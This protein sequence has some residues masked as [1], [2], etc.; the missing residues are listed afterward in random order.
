M[1]ILCIIIL[2]LLTIL[3]FKLLLRPIYFI[4][5]VYKHNFFLMMH[6]LFPP[7][8]PAEYSML[9]INTR[10]LV[11]SREGCR[12][13]QRHLD[14]VTGNDLRS[15]TLNYFHPTS[16]RKSTNHRMLLVKYLKKYVIIFFREVVM[17]ESF[18]DLE[19]LTTKMIKC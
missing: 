11:Y 18:L 6:G 13:W 10:T 14:K 16:L 17:I 4:T 3:Y 1:P 2:L 12:M 9:L 8:L 19:I 7:P 5:T 15:L